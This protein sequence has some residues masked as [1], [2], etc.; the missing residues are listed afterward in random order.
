MTTNSSKYGMSVEALSELCSEITA[1]GKSQAKDGEGAPK[2]V[3]VNAQSG[4]GE[5][6]CIVTERHSRRGINGGSEITIRRVMGAGI[7]MLTRFSNHEPL[8]G[9]TIE[10]LDA[11]QVLADALRLGEPAARHDLNAPLPP[12]AVKA[13]K[14][15]RLASASAL[16]AGTAELTIEAVEGL[17]ASARM[18]PVTRTMVLSTL[19]AASETAG[20]PAVRA[21]ARVLAAQLSGD[22]PASVEPALVIGEDDAPSGDDDAADILASLESE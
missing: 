1:R 7:G 14:G 22:S 13:E 17:A 6:L 19:R 12:P 15:P 4:A 9:F 8:S 10:V 11:Q 16:V 2:A 5:A 3:F 20:D 21:R 18:M